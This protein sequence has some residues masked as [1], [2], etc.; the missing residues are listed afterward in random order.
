M[1]VVCNCKY[2]IRNGR[3][4]PRMIMTCEGTIG[5]IDVEFPHSYDDNY[6]VILLC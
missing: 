4:G 3:C 1:Q 5:N 6:F 2:G